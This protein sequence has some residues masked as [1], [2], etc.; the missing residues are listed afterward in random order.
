MKK[1][2][3]TLSVFA[4]LTACGDHSA[5]IEAGDGDVISSISSSGD[6]S[7]EELARQNKADLEAEEQRIAE[8]E[9]S[10][11]TLEFDKLIHDFGDVRQG[12]ENTTTFEVR[13]TGDKPLIISDVS[14]SCGCTTPRKPEKPIPPGKSDVIEVTFKPK[15]GQKDLIKKTVTVTANSTPDEITK[16]E[17]KAF[18]IE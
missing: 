1:V 17:I 6:L 8:M 7:D 11:T 13:N 3:L 14:A 4:L 16:L 9:A 15:P 2:V 5:T 12:S 10:K 18:V